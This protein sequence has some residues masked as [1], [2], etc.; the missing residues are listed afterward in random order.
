MG[1]LGSVGPLFSSMQC[2]GIE[3]STGHPSGTVS[4]VPAH[5]WQVFWLVTGSLVWLLATVPFHEACAS[6]SVTAGFQDFPGEGS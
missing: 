6:Q 2:G 3:L 5:S 1:L 4:V